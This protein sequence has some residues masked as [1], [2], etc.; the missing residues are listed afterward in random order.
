MNNFVGQ[1]GHL[2]NRCTKCDKRNIPYLKSKMVIQSEPKPL[3]SNQKIQEYKHF[4]EK[5]VSIQHITPSYY[6][7]MTLEMIGKR[8][9]YSVRTEEYTI[10]DILVK[11]VGNLPNH[12]AGCLQPIWSPKCI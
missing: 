5:I 9:V 8:P 2:L 4:S 7:N 6:P 3:N 10:P 1:S 11:N 12:D